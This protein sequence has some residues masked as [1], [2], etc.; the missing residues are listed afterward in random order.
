MI[1]AIVFIL[2]YV[3]I[4]V[5]QRIQIE[6]AAIALLT[7]V[8]SWIILAVF[9]NGHELGAELGGHLTEIASV[10]FFLLGAMTIVEVMDRHG[11]FLFISD[12]I[13]LSN[14]RVLLVVVS[15]V[16]FFL[17]AVL[18]NLTTT[19]IMVSVSRKLVCNDRDR[20]FFAGLIVIAAN[21]GGAFSPIGDVTTTM[22]WIGGQISAARL[23]SKLFLPSLVSLVVPLGLMLFR[24]SAI[25]EVCAV[26]APD[27]GQSDTRKGLRG[28]ILALGLVLIMVV[29]VG[30]VLT[31]LPPYILMLGSLGTMWLV[32]EIIHR[33]IGLGEHAE[34]SV[35]TALSEIDLSSVLFFVGILLAVAALQTGGVL[36]A[37]AGQLTVWFPGPEAVMIVLGLVSAVVDNVPLVSAAMKMFPL[38]VYPIDS[39]LWLLLAY[40]AGTGGSLLIIGSAAGISAMGTSRISF[41]WYFKQISWMALGGYVAG[42]AVFLLSELV[43]G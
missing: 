40:T 39:Q 38:A 4:S 6:K 22:L 3:L 24:I 9:A 5:E 29:P 15:L 28:L 1:V 25:P 23:I 14:R 17:S 21:A 11:A 26:V 20:M 13:H 10:V 36:A 32:T 12:H 35:Q 18:D 27:V 31:G 41:G 34:F 8:A 33:K 7:G 42:I 19:I 37:V 2:G 16:T 30:K 43:T